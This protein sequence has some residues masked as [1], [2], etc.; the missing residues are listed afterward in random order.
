[1][2]RTSTAL[3]HLTT[4]GSST[5]SSLRRR[6]IETQ[7]AFL[8]VIDQEL[9]FF[10]SLAKDLRQLATR[11]TTPQEL[12][13]VI[14]IGGMGWIDADAIDFFMREN[15]TILSNSEILAIFHRFTA[16]GQPLRAR[17]TFDTFRR[18]IHTGQFRARHRSRSPKINP[19][20]RESPSSKHKLPPKATQVSRKTKYKPVALCSGRRAQLT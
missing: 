10:N 12:F 5:P 13:S 19:R 11:N 8:R 16:A 6:K 9:R 20:D 3:R 4:Q 2:P 7:W 1:M 18:L 15:G 14:D 17:I